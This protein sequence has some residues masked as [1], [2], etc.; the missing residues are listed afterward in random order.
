MN[1]VRRT[2]QAIL[3]AVIVV[4]PVLQMAS[5]AYAAVT[6]PLSLSASASSVVQGG[7]VTV[8]VYENSGSE[9]VNAVQANFTYPASSLQYDSISNSSAFGVVAQNSGGSGSVSIARGT[10]SPVSGQ[11][12]VASVTFT[13]LASSGSAALAIAAGSEVV[14]STNTDVS[15]TSSGTSITLTAPVHAPTPTPT[16]KPTSS[17]SSSSS[18]KPSSSSSSATPGAPALQISGVSVS[19]ITTS[20]VTVTWTT[21]RAATSEVDYGLT[22]SYGLSA[23]SSSAVTAHSVVLN[24]ALIAPGTTYHFIVMSTDSSG[25]K[26]TGTDATFTTAGTSLLITVLNQQTGKPVAGAKVSYGGKTA[27]T[28]QQGQATLTNLPLGKSTITVSINGKSSPEVVQLD[29]PSTTL[30]P[31][32]VFFKVPVQAS[33]NGTL[34]VVIVLIVACLAALFGGMRLQKRGKNVWAAMPGNESV[35]VGGQSHAAVDP[36]A[37]LPP[38]AGPTTSPQPLSPQPHDYNGP[39]QPTNGGNPPARLVQ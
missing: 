17:G 35:V 11:Q 6:A 28:N 14:S 20:S 12:L 23:V 36:L 3:L 8:Y 31:Q 10:I 21:N 32:K 5:P 7:T 37:G 22:E 9:P 30:S 26:A 13:A 4:V 33:L 24:S 25:K 39:I 16:P 38:A 19:A 2:I 18:S 15:G 34:I 1:I 29:K 27:T